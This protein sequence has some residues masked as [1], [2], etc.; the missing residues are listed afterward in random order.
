MT[1]S[2][3]ICIYSQQKT[4]STSLFYIFKNNG[5]EVDKRHYNFD[6]IKNI[7]YDIII[8]PFRK[9]KDIIIS[10]YFENIFNKFYKQYTIKDINE[11][12][13]IPFEEH[14]LNIKTYDWNKDFHFTIL[15]MEFTLEKIFD[16]NLKKQKFKTYKIIKKINKFTEHKTKIV[17]CNFIK[18]N[19]E[20]K[21]K[22]FED[23]KLNLSNI[24]FHT[25]IGDTKWYKDIYIKMKKE[26][27]NESFD[28]LYDLSFE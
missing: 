8:I 20:E 1:I 12:L 22:M 25:N 15:S 16:I 14:L 7:N 6:A 3:K 5:I 4:G 9:I 2:K 24:D 27:E 11:I 26:L 18:M 23:L 21:Q 10:G 19:N 13:K 28:K 17:L